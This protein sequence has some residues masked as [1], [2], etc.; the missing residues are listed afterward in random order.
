[1]KRGWAAFLLAGLLLAGCAP[2]SPGSSGPA[3][4]GPDVSVSQPE[5][6]PKEAIKEPEWETADGVRVDWSRL[7]GRSQPQPNVD[8]GRCYPQYMDHLITGADYGPLVPY[9]GDQAYSFERWEHEGEMQK[10]FSYWPT[11]FYGL[12]TREG[13]IVVDPVYQN[14]WPYSYRWEGEDHAL[15]VLILTRVDPKWKEFGSGSRCAVAAED[16]SWMTDFEFLNYTNKEDQLFL[17]RPEGCTVLD[18]KTGSRK[19]WSWKELDMPASGEE[20]SETLSFIQWVTGLNW[21]DQGVCLG[22]G[23]SDPDLSWDNT[24]ARVFRPETGEVYWVEQ[25]QW[26]Q[27]YDEYSDRRWSDMGKLVHE[28][29]GATLTVD[30]QSYFLKDTYETG[31]L[32]V[33]RGD[34]AI[35]DEQH[36]GNN[37]WTLYRLSTGERLMEGT[38]F[39][40][41][42]DRLRPNSIFPAA[43][44][45]G[46]WTVFNDRLEP[47]LTLPPTQ[48]DNWVQVSLQDGLLTFKENDGIFFGAY[49][50]DKGEYVFF[51]NLDMGD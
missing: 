1:M 29:S 2:Q 48:R 5:E 39:E 35:L 20:L 11:S 25:R 46:A 28:N 34:F 4:S 49:D 18:S 47:V 43:Y 33:K 6:P 44:E 13:K 9:L 42:A 36:A 40:L 32:S 22:W 23:Q 30:G 16:G 51:R 19:D 3:A 8:G 27:W 41:I 14:V 24:P 17:L 10:Y 12:M 38:D 31:R 15:P 21:L 26:D 37:I 7:G 50:L 45:R